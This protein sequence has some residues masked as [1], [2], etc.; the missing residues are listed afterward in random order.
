M[1]WRIGE[2][3]NAISQRPAPLR[4]I[5]QRLRAGTNARLTGKSGEREQ[6]SEQRQKARQGNHAEKF[7]TFALRRVKG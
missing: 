5:G 1:N 7:C 3:R 6:P 4:P 2:R